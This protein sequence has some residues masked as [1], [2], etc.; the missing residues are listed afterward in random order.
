MKE[1]YFDDYTI[2]AVMHIN[3]VWFE[4]YSIRNV[5]TALGAD[6]NVPS[7]SEPNCDEWYI[8]KKDDD[9][10]IND[11][12]LFRWI[13]MVDTGSDDL[14]RFRRF[15]SHSVIP[16]MYI[17]H[18]ENKPSEPIGPRQSALTFNE[19]EIKFIIEDGIFWF[20]VADMKK[21]TGYQSPS[22]Q[23]VKNIRSEYLAVKSVHTTGGD[24]NVHLISLDGMRELAAHCYKKEVKAFVEYINVWT[25]GFSAMHKDICIT[26]PTE[27]KPVETEPTEPEQ[28]PTDTEL[29][30]N[31]SVNEDIKYIRTAIASIASVVKDLHSTS[32]R[33][34]RSVDALLKSS[35][36]AMMQYYMNHPEMQE[37]MRK[38]DRLDN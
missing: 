1:F 25:D 17:Q 3:A 20:V 11:S 21:A 33:T 14:S 2:K 7:L 23:I 10:F 28:K 5:L 12:A 31:E 38:I 34:Q 24:Q 32:D 13:A 16:T 4:V 22:T 35:P 15:I 6:S 8:P 29:I 27:T 18:F 30:Q 37:T 9:R 19:T 26:V 36:A